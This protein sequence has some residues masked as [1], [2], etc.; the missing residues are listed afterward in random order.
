MM[1]DIDHFKNINDT[2]GHSAG[3]QI[4]VEAARCMRACCAKRISSAALAGMSL[5]CC[6][7]KPAKKRTA[8]FRTAARGSCPTY[9][10]GRGHIHADH[11]QHG[12]DSHLSDTKINLD[13]LLQEAIKR[14]IFSKHGDETAS[15]CMKILP[16]SSK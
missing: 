3:D 1:I 12:S 5:S 9:R 7:L 2:F 15:R 8:A 4:L 6:C 11:R 10:D 13:Q 16:H 14:S